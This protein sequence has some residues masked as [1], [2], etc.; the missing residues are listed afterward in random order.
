[1]DA[2]TVF[3]TYDEHV[4][5]CMRCKDAYTA[6]S[7]G[8][9]IEQCQIGSSLRMAWHRVMDRTAQKAGS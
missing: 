1:M 5:N 3:E 9:S 8:R 4:E 7:N 6:L 2:P